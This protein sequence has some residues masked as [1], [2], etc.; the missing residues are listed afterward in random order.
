MLPAQNKHENFFDF[1]IPL[2]YLVI[3]LE[4]VICFNASTS[5]VKYLYELYCNM[6][7]RLLTT[8]GRTERSGVLCESRWYS[9]MVY[10]LKFPPKI[11]FSLFIYGCPIDVRALQCRLQ[12]TSFDSSSSCVIRT[13]LAGQSHEIEC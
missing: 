9:I 1:S 6:R 2:S 12:N 8:D 11:C 5:F 13:K 10:N 7:F 3:S 4:L